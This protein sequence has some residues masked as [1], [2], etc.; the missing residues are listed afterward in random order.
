MQKY[1]HGKP[2]SKN[3]QSTGMMPMLSC[4]H[5]GNPACRSEHPQKLDLCQASY[6][7]G[8]EGTYAAHPLSGF[9]K[10]SWSALYY[11]GQRD[12]HA[13]LLGYCSQAQSASRK[14]KRSE[15]EVSL[16]KTSEVLAVL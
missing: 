1:I 13:Y 8:N 15:R 14:G 3:V 16:Q 4:Q 12:I 10:A 11:C 9:H 2:E 5:L 7:V 6:P